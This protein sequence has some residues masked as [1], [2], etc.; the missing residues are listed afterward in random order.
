MY[1]VTKENYQ[2]SA[3]VSLLVLPTMV[4]PRLPPKLSPLLSIYVYRVSQ[5]SSLPLP[6]TE[7]L[8][9]NFI[10]QSRDDRLAKL[11]LFAYK[12]ELKNEGC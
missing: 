4:D 1:Y 11:T 5:P 7:P 6:I 12:C 8:M 10:I 3:R 2:N 9:V